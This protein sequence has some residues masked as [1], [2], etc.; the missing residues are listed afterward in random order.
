MRLPLDLRL[1]ARRPLDLHLSILH[2]KVNNNRLLPAHPAPSCEGL[3]A[4]LAREDAYAQHAFDALDPL[5]QRLHLPEAFLLLSSGSRVCRQQQCPRER[6]IDDEVSLVR[7]ERT[8]LRGLAALP[9]RRPR[10]AELVT[11]LRQY[12]GN[13]ERLDFDWYARPL[14]QQPCLQLA[15]VCHTDEAARVRRNELLL[16]QARA[17][18]FNTVQ[19][20]VDLIGAVET[21][22]HQRIGR[23]GIECQWREAS[24]DDQ[25]P[26]LV[27]CRY[28]AHRR[29]CRQLERL[30]RFYYVNYR[31]A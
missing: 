28:E 16:V 14:C 25:L 8:F 2:A 22:V 17:T 19:L 10:G 7:L 5:C 15:V 6:R 30:D 29:K 1:L 12:C 20:F 18:T 27:A 4:V 13:G 3:L 21:D 9:Y 11:Q 31:A 26:R 23:Q 24:I